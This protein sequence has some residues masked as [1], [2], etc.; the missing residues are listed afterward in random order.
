M[1]HKLRSLLPSP[2]FSVHPFGW[3]GV[4]NWNVK[5][6]HVPVLRSV[7]L[8]KLSCWVGRCACCLWLNCWTEKAHTGSLR[9]WDGVE[10]V[11]EFHYQEL[12]LIVCTVCV[13]CDVIKRMTL[14]SRFAGLCMCM[15][16]SQIIDFYSSVLLLQYSCSK[17]KSDRPRL[18]RMIG[19]SVASDILG[20]SCLCASET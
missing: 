15:S 20:R 4:K 16:N 10:T 2:A 5:W 9:V 13:S 8:N 1:L 18:T 11:A 6:W 14:W 7:S 17:N 19:R 3:L 12:L